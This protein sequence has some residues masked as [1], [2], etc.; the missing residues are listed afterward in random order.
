MR[1]IAEHERE[2]ASTVDATMNARPFE[3][4]VTA[5]TKF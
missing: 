3:S 1:K 2:S 4:L 5:S